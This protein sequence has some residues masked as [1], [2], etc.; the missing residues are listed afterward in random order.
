MLHHPDELAAAIADHEAAER[1]HRDAPRWLAAARSRRL[2]GAGMR[3]GLRGSGGGGG[4]GGAPW[5]P[6]QLSN[7]LHYWDLS[8]DVTT[9]GGDVTNVGDQVGSADMASTGAPPEY[10][11][12][13][14]IF[15]GA[16]AANFLN[17]FSETLRATRGSTLAQTYTKWVVGSWDNTGLRVMWGASSP[18]RSILRLN[19]SSSALEL[20]AGPGNVAQAT[21]TPALNTAYL[22]VCV[23]SSGSPALYVNNTSLTLSPSTIGSLGAARFDWAYDG[24]T[25]GAVR[26]AAGGVVSGAMSASDRAALYAWA[27]ANKGVA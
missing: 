8:T 18:S 21:N 16:P 17:T 25:Y 9:S 10:V 14:A 24:T 13:S 2:G 11:A 12:S 27:Q 22:Y 19:S 4:G 26:I 1:L 7:G 15:G 20:Y 23:M 6:S 3:R 5:E